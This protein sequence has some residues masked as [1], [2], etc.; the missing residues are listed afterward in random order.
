MGARR[1][2]ILRLKCFLMSIAALFFSGCNSMI[3]QSLTAFIAPPAPQKMITYTIHDFCPAA[4]NTFNEIFLINSSYVL[5]GGQIQVDSDRDGVP[6]FLDNDPDLGI[7]RYDAFSNANWFGDLSIF[8]TGANLK[9]QNMIMASSS[10]PNPLQDTDGDGIPD[11]AETLLIKS[12]PKNFDTDG[13]G[14]P[15]ELE[16]RF[17]L[18]P[19]DPSDA[20]LN[21]SGDGISNL[22]KVKMQIPLRETSTPTISQ[23]AHQ[24]TVTPLAPT[25][26][27]ATPFDL[28]VSQIPIIGVNNGNLII[29]YILERSAAAGSSSAAT[30]LHR[31]C[32]LVSNS[33]TQ[34]G[35]SLVIDYS[36]G[37][38]NELKNPCPLDTS[39]LVLAP[40]GP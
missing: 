17:G 11:C 7:T 30:Q 32:S 9:T 15:D 35:D 39:Q 28:K 26:T 31:V 22:K 27:C 33:T 24:Y 13:D 5:T 4:G 40:G 2:T 6:D 10:C 12:D 16:L 25:P 3:L 1:N 34:N 21:L 23:Y 8:A 29:S 20:Q 38:E 14:I 37:V 19:L 18:N 36:T